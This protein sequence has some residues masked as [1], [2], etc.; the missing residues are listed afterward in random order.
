MTG[1]RPRDAPS[2]DRTPNCRGYLA[3]GGRTIG[4]TPQAHSEARTTT[5]R[6]DRWTEIDCFPP[7]TVR[8]HTGALDADNGFKD[9]K[10]DGGLAF[11]GWNSQTP[12]TETSTHYFWSGAANKKEDKPNRAHLLLGSLSATCAE[13]KV[14]VEAQQASMDKVPG[15]QLVMIASDAGMVHARRLVR[16]MIDDEQPAPGASDTRLPATMCELLAAGP[17]AL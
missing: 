13:Y 11:W 2:I 5:D 6:I 8:I 3:I 9:G 7:C 10:R 16:K 12:E 15:R 4:G 14:V 17:R 1:S